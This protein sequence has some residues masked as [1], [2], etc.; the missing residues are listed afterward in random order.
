MCK[1]LLQEKKT[2]LT[3]NNLKEVFKTSHCFFFYLKR[4]VTATESYTFTYA[5]HFTTLPIYSL[6][7]LVI[8]YQT[9][10]TEESILNRTFLY[11]CEECFVKLVKQVN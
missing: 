2:I 9:L 3:V 7:V 11:L 8:L 5:Y 10:C 4:R 1:F 6:T